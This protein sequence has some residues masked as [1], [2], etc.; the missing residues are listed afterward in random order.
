M[1]VMEE[2]TMIQ[3][4]SYT[5]HKIPS[6]ITT[7]Q[8]NIMLKSLSSLTLV[9]ILFL[10]TS[11]CEYN[12]DAPVREAEVDA[13]QV[14]SA[15]HTSYTKRMDRASMEAAQQAY[16]IADDITRPLRFSTF[17]EDQDESRSIAE[18]FQILDKK[19]RDL[20]ATHRGTAIGPPLALK[21]SHSM[22]HSDL[23]GAPGQNALPEEQRMEAVRYYLQTLIK[24]K[25]TDFALQ[26]RVLE[27]LAPHHPD[28]VQSLAREALANLDAFKKALRQ[29]VKIPQ[30]IKEEAP[31]QELK[32]M[33]YRMETSRQGRLQ[34]LNENPIRPQLAALA[35]QIE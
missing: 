16:D 21:L 12:L 3:N 9:L 31:A 8:A 2:T 7:N 25:D 13:K 19:A 27:T 26:V 23:L 24:H 30:W 20:I 34:W 6:Q 28:E 35:G 11:G 18:N 32:D 22:L 1:V 5:P 15:A 29:P 17:R 14:T 4:G 33:R 10:A